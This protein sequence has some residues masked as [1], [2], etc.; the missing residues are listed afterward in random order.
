M[1]TNRCPFEGGKVKW[2][3]LACR[4]VIEA[5]SALQSSLHF[6]VVQFQ[7]SDL[8]CKVRITPAIRA[9]SRKTYLA[10]CTR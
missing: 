6:G 8:L 10:W 7:G 4:M 2:A 1:L 5:S 3:H 9:N